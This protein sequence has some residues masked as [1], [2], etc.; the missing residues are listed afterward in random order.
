MAA[1]I[2]ELTTQYSAPTVKQH[3]AALS[4]LFDWL[5]IGQ[6]ISFNPASSV[7]APKHIVREGKTP[8]LDENEMR[9]LLD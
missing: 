1:Y 5:V 9:R 6:V 3:L 8:I 2:E 4:M 7:K